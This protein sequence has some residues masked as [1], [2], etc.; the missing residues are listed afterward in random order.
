MEQYDEVR[1][2]GKGSFGSVFPNP[3]NLA[4]RH[5]LGKQSKALWLPGLPES[6]ECTSLAVSQR[7]N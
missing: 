4:C 7:S 1:Q 3:E 2:L 5:I 6:V